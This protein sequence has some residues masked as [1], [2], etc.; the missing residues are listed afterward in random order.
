MNFQVNTKISNLIRNN[1]IEQ[2]K[3]QNLRLSTK[4]NY[5]LIRTKTHRKQFSL[6]DYFTIDSLKTNGEG[7]VNNSSI[8]YK[9]FSYRSPLIDRQKSNLFKLKNISFRKSNIYLHRVK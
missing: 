2:N 8:L 6:C 1:Q 4:T 9:S 7:K 3:P 5:D